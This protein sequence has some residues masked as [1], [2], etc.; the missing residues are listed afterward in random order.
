MK[1]EEEKQD[2]RKT[3]FK[4]DP[5]NRQQLVLIVDEIDQ[6]MGKTKENIYEIGK[7]LTEAKGLVGHS[8]FQRW[9][10]ANFD[11]S[12][13]TANNFMNVYRF[14]LNRPKLVNSIKS[15]VLYTISSNNFPNDLREHLLE[16][17]NSLS[18]IKSKQIKDIMKRFKKKEIDLE[19]PEIKGL[20]QY[21][22][23]K[24]KFKGHEEV[25][26]SCLGKLRHLERMVADWV[27]SI[28]WPASP[29]NAKLEMTQDQ[30]KDLN[31]IRKDLD[32]AIGT[33]FPKVKLVPLLEPRLKE[34]IEDQSLKS[35]N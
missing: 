22:E 20:I 29:D 21:R 3:Y 35:I 31:D 14:C 23:E 18:D 25:I 17:G 13:P 4:D 27:A 10:E 9:I 2:L 1:T 8:N 30:I 24:S 15:S 26:A 6:I 7:L 5:K 28:I 32:K 33:A 12:Y 19:S 16:H 34:Y 11:F